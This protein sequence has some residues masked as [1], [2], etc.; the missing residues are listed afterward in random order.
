MS[1]PKQPADEASISTEAEPK[2]QSAETSAPATDAA[3]PGA[4]ST[5]EA[6]GTEQ[7]SPAEAA[8]KERAPR[9]HPRDV[10][11]RFAAAW[12]QAFSTEPKAVKPLTVGVLKQI[13]ANRPSELD[14][15]NSQAIRAGMK[16]YA[17]RM[18]YHIAMLNHSHRVDLA[19]EQA[20]EITDDMRTH[21]QEQLDAIK[22]QRAEKGGQKGKR[23]G[24]RADEGDQAGDEAKGDS[25]G[26]SRGDSKGRP[27]RARKGDRGES[28]GEGGRPRKPAKSRD[29][30]SRQQ[31]GRDDASRQLPRD[32]GPEL[33]LEEKLA[34]L[35]EHFGK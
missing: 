8:D 27:R 13:L 9:V 12:P 3:A 30:R 21:A 2:T 29:G 17:S 23:S 1:D 32:E 20:E 5:A 19:G 18:A 11:A 6:A 15:L 24:R 7:K 22:A 28:R 35:A 25:R 10:I 14:G 31:S 26:D 34:K 4:A 16:F 33:S